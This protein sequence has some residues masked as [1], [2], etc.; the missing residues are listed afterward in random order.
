MSRNI[1]KTT[2][3]VELVGFQAIMRPSRYGYLLECITVEE[4]L[5]DQL[6]DERVEM[7]EKLVEKIENPRMALLRP[8]P[9]IHLPEEKGFNMKFAWKEHTRP[10]VIDYTGVEITSESYPLY[11]GARCQLAMYQTPYLLK[12][13]ESEEVRYGTTLR[14][15]GIQVL[16]L[17]NGDLNDEVFSLEEAR[18][19]FG[20]DF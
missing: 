20:V 6:E 16:E 8:E 15:S 14:L 13:P 17:G 19:M 10:P 7:L 18:K 3:P 2:I 1:I 11:A 9:W 12:D 5:I 4:E